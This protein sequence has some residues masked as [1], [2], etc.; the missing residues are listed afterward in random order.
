MT[1][2]RKRRVPWPELKDAH[3]GHRFANRLAFD[4]RAHEW[5]IVPNK[6]SAFFDKP[7]LFKTERDMT[8][9][10][11]DKMVLAG[12]FVRHW[13]DSRLVLGTSINRDMGRSNRRQ[14]GKGGDPDLFWVRDGMCGFIELKWDRRDERVDPM[15]NQEFVIGLLT[16]AGEK[17]GVFY[18][19]DFVNGNL[20]EFLGIGPDTF[21][22][23]M[24]DGLWH[25]LRQ[26]N[27]EP[28]R[29]MCSECN[30]RSKRYG[31][32]LDDDGNIVS[33]LVPE[34]CLVQQQKEWNG[35]S[36]AMAKMILDAPA[37][38]GRSYV[39]FVHHPLDRHPT[40]NCSDTCY[41]GIPGAPDSL[42]VVGGKVVHLYL[43]ERPLDTWQKRWKEQIQM[44]GGM[45]AKFSM[46]DKKDKFL[47]SL[48]GL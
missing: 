42:M 40:D 34:Y 26:W 11:V 48:F 46:K 43:Q 16:A 38:K 45:V 31:A 2:E 39:F 36:E 10:L 37:I 1:I 41:L 20:E 29:C 19:Q 4:D 5:G 23:E 14:R 12:F 25:D 7:F 18:H 6:R 44:S 33:G 13:S 30:H 32:G 17:V 35:I 28:V 8:E 3:K 27:R 22:D 15:P 9:Y 47:R 24:D 21:N